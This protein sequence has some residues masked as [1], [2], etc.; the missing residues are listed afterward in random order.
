MKAAFSKYAVGLA[1]GTVLLLGANGCSSSQVTHHSGQ[2]G[3]YFGDGISFSVPVLE[4]STTPTGEDKFWEVRQG[5]GGATVVILGPFVSEGGAPSFRE[6]M[7]LST[8]KLSAPQNVESF[9]QSQLSEFKGAYA[10]VVSGFS[11]GQD[12]T[13]YWLTFER[14]EA[15]RVLFHK[16]WFFVDEGRSLGFVLVGTVQKG[17]H[18]DAC[19]QD[20]N[21]IASTVRFGTPPSGFA[22]LSEELDK[23]MACTPSVGIS[24]R[25]DDN[26]QA[27]VTEPE[28]AVPSAAS[29]AVEAPASASNA[30]QASAAAVPATASPAQGAVEAEAPPANVKSSN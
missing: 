23:A 19:V 16:A 30:R 17:T 2:I 28:Q 9:R 25:A 24:V 13:G 4:R 10:N 5:I 3:R 15:G 7:V 29:H 26:P 22:W 6:N 12:E 21:R 18:Q 1:L 11:E 8:H 20:F 14:S 27:T